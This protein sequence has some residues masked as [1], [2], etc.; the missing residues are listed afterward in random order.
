[1]L[2]RLNK[3]TIHTFNC[4]FLISLI[5]V[6]QITSVSAEAIWKSGSSTPPRNSDPCINYKSAPCRGFTRTKRIKIYKLGD[7]ITAQWSETQD[8]FGTFQFNLLKV[9]PATGADELLMPIFADV[10]DI[11]NG[12]ITGTQYHEYQRDFIFPTR[13]ANGASIPTGDYV[14]QLIHRATKLNVVV[15]ANTNPAFNYYSCS[16]IRIE[17]TNA[18]DVISPDNVSNY[19][20]THLVN[21]IVLDW[22]NPISNGIATENL[23]YKILVL[24]DIIPITITAAELA[25]TEYSRDMTVAS[26]TAI[27]SYVGNGETVTVLNTGTT[28]YY[29]KIFLMMLMEIILQGLALLSQ[30]YH[31][32]LNKLILP[33]EVC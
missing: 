12:V 10:P 21:S 2:R 7:S 1:M 33:M 6:F 25:N 30:K 18:N 32:P 31:F 22:V 8:H 28:N 5:S 20:L 11:T 29:F 3:I 14:L 16:D 26:S 9:I 19:N 17:N 15:D 13:L 27:V 23:A 4:I 24:K